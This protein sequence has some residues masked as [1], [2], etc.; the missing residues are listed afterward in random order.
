[1]KTLN[2]ITVAFVSAVGLA[3]IST[4][5][6]ACA[7]STWT[8]TSGNSYA[9]T[10]KGRDCGG[11]MSVRMTG[12]FGDTG[13]I[14]MYKNGSTNFKAQYGDGQ[15][16]TDISM[17]TNGG[18]MSAYFVHKASGGQHSTTKGKYVLTGF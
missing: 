6:S 9:D 3:A 10:I 2:I 5:A 16:L 7:T 1:M 15:V 11:N 8:K 12:G 4:P 14:P 18:T 17:K 13:W